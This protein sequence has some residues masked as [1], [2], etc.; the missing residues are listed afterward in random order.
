[1]DAIKRNEQYKAVAQRA[2]KMG[3]VK[4]TH[5]KIDVIL[6]INCA[7]DYRRLNLDKLI[8]LDDFSF[9]HDTARYILSYIIPPYRNY[10]YNMVAV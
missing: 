6:D 7:D 2:F 9:S 5:G 3:L 4:T 8:E 1:M 10:P